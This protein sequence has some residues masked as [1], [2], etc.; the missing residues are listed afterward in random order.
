MKRIFLYG[1]SGAQDQYR[2]VE[3]WF[4][5]IEKEPMTIKNLLYHAISLKVW[6]PGI[7]QVYAIDDRRGLRQDYMK[8]CKKNSIESWA[9][10]KNILQTEGLRII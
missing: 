4:I 6:N 3:Y 10:F 1:I 8:S 2:V 5:N 7:E 9:I